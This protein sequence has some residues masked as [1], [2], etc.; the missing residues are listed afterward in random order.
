MIK[1][2]IVEDSITAQCLLSEIL[3]SDSELAVIGT[4]SD[5][6]EALEFLKRK[7]ADVITMDFQMPRM[8]GIEVTRRIMETEPV[9]I[10]IISANWRPDNKELAF[11]FMEAGAVAVLEKP[12]GSTVADYRGAAEKLIQTVKSMAEVKLV[13]R[14]KL[15]ALIDEPTPSGGTSVDKQTKPVFVLEDRRDFDLELV[16][17]GASTGGPPVIQ[18]ILS[19]IKSDFPA[20]IVV[21]QHIAS[22]FLEG[23]AEWLGNTVPMKIKILEQGEFLLAGSVYLAPTG[24][25][26]GISA[27]RQANLSDNPP[28]YG[29]KPAVSYLFRSLAKNF[30]NRAVGVLLT[31]MGA[32]GAAELKR[33]KDSGAITIAQDQQSSTV[34]GMPG[35]AV[36]L[37]AAK[38]VLPPEK[39]VDLLN[40]VVLVPAR[41]TGD[42]G[43]LR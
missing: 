9:P 12:S 40:K 8:N 13:R 30:H 5:G 18:S 39:I 3:K 21:V 34:F 26:V 6:V 25:Q 22:G 35:E 28:E 7:K 16:A 38:Y 2:L 36:K 29:V 37:G 4:V 17:I 41:R 20:P 42:F 15:G 43:A 31:G 11:R 23:M 10:I 33:M 14:R 32:D 24:F 1:V 27:T 19:G